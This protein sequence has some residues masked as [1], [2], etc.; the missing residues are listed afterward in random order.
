MHNVDS[1]RAAIKLLH[2][3]ITFHSLLS[4]RHSLIK[5][6][7]GRNPMRMTVSIHG[8]DIIQDKFWAE[9]PFK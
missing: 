1:L 8:L 6:H 5:N 7:H 4:F 9:Y 2:R 3:Y